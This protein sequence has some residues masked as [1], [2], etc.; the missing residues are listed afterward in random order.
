MEHLDLSAEA[1]TKPID[2]YLRVATVSPEVALA[3][4]PTNVAHIQD[5]YSAAARQQ[6][7]LVVMPELCLTGYTAADMFHNQHVIEQS[8]V[9]LQT[10]AEITQGGP[11][12]MVGAPLEHNGVL[13]NCG[14]VI[15][16]GEIVGAVPKSYL[17]N[18]K[19]FYEYR[20][21][22]SGK[23]IQNET[24]Q[25]GEQAVPFGTD[26]LFN[27]N[28]TKVGMEI[29]EDMFAAIS[30]GTTAALGGAEVVVNLSASNELIG[31]ADYRRQLI[32]NFT[33][34][35][36]CGY[37][38]ASSGRGESVADVIYGGHQVISENGRLSNERA[39]L[40][41]DI[42]PLLYDIDRTYLQHDRIV[43]KTFA[44]QALEQQAEHP[45]RQLEIAVP[46]PQSI[47]VERSI[48]AHPFVPSNPE[49]LDARC[50]EIFNDLAHALAQRINDSCA[51]AIV[52]GLS[53]GLDSTLALLTAT[54][55]C[56]LLGKPYNFVHTITMP[57]QASSHR[58]QSNADKLAFAI[59][60]TQRVIAIDSL[61]QDFMQAIGHD[62][63]TEDLT[64][65]NTQARIRTT[66]LMNYANMVHG[67]VEG[68]GDMSENAI[69][70]CTYNGDHMSMFNPNGAVPKTLV[71]HLVRWYAERRAD[72]K[73]AFI[74][75]DILDT[76]ISP[77]LTGKGDL[78]QTTEDIV[79]PYELTDFF[80][81]EH[82]R[83]GSRPNKIG[84]LAVQAFEDK[85]DAETIAKWLDTFMRRFT[86][87][88]WK[89]DVMPNSTKI[90]SISE[91]PRGDLRMAPNT[92]PNWYK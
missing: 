72:E 91:S 82:L 18:Y 34:R 33:G 76:P 35:A 54:Y 25:I 79:G 55:A 83:Y 61:A 75:Q 19:E 70:W 17:P 44:E 36:I 5:A 2:D 4:V 15:A 27:I 88:Q 60:T 22:S 13:Y 42:S 14:V 3:D 87:S 41:D 51:E 53:G 29:C 56:D 12:L 78:S 47:I 92:S 9:G 1:F 85:Y 10:L 11:A 20:W 28:G 66:L 39:P 21:F 32:S 31:K 16:N 50:E 43:N 37:V 24:L 63:T 8:L 69:G 81:Y 46:K 68:T 40:S 64:Y 23:T 57:G 48:D 62:Q 84:Y 30:P 49:T 74:L 26:L 59:G 89:R 45:Y 65:E 80:L 86:G 71:S 38:Y 90:G 73:A 7:E 77:E 52:L 67:F 58:T 6:A